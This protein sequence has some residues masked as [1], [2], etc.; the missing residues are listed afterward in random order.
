MKKK[1]K[2]TTAGSLPKYDWLAETQT[3]WPQWKVSGDELWDKQKKSAKLW[4]E[5]QENAGL[6]IVSEGEQF[7]IHFVH[8]F[9]E[10]ISGID[11]DKK[12]QMGIRN[13]RYTVEVPTVTD[14]VQRQGSVHLKEASFL[15]EN[16][17]SI[18]KFT[19]P[20]PLTISDT[21][22]N[23]YYTSSQDMAMHFAELLNDEA[24][25]LAN[26]GIDIIQFDEPA[27]NSFT[28]ESIDWGMEALGIA[29]AKLDCKT[30]VHI[31][32]GYGIEENLNW[33]KTLGDQWKEYESL[34]P[35]INKSNIDQISLEFAGSNVP[36][37]LMRLL[38][39]KEI[40][41]GV[42]G[43][44]N[45]HIETP[46]EVKDNILEALKHMDSERLIA[47]SNCGMAPISVDVA[48]RKIRALGLGAELAYQQINNNL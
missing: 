19:L 7:R 31:C 1:F 42:I 22:A 8:G 32:Y 13:D 15:R 30:A 24:K 27:F 3:L 23:D 5:E 38:P 39:D 40:M 35:E 14:A 25:E 43:V 17:E 26:A 48:K 41:V 11:W 34:F 36:P 10:K 21:I 44:V 28:T 29:A 46:D 2:A 20:G 4:I 37:E 16:S 18:T 45:D 12:T 33:K 6:E 47:C 9:L